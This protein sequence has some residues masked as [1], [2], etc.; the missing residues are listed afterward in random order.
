MAKIG[1]LHEVGGWMLEVFQKHTFLYFFTF[2]HAFRTRFLI[3]PPPIPNAPKARSYKIKMCSNNAPIVAK[4][5]GKFFFSFFYFQKR[6]QRN[7]MCVINNFHKLRRS[8]GT[9]CF[10]TFLRHSAPTE[11]NKRIQ[12]YSTRI[13]FLRNDF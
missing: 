3:F 9:Q 12:I 5:H 10:F 6:F 7:Q 11:R 2:R 8:V 4:I 13:T 1:N